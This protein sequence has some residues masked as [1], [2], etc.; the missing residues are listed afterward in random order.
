MAEKDIWQ[1]PHDGLSSIKP[2]FDS[3]SGNDHAV[4][5]HIKLS[6]VFQLTCSF[7]QVR[8]TKFRAAKLHC[9]G[10]A[11]GSTRHMS[12]RLHASNSKYRT[13]YAEFLKDLS[14]SYH[15]LA[16]TLTHLM[17]WI[18]WTSGTLWVPRRNRSVANKCWNVTSVW[19]LSSGADHLGVPI[20]ALPA[21]IVADSNKVARPK[22]VI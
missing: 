10:Q 7:V 9:S 18:P 15:V 3:F 2:L 5:N 6:I 22:S 17:D 12:S 13:H 1:M 14:F 20:I 11:A 21:K 16:L 19:R 8:A 4:P